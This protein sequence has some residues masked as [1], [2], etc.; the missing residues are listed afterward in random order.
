MKEIQ[1]TSCRPPDL[2]TYSVGQSPKEWKRTS[3]DSDTICYLMREALLQSKDLVFKKSTCFE[4]RIIDFELEEEHQTRTYIVQIHSLPLA[5][6]ILGNLLNTS[7]CGSKIQSACQFFQKGPILSRTFYCLKSPL[8][9][10][11][12][13]SH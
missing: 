2:I 8:N 13:S 3:A 5:N 1:R 12:E 7:T 4:G 9:S 10:V 11:Q 6:K